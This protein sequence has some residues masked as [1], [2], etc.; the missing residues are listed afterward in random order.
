MP[1]STHLQVRYSVNLRRKGDA[2]VRS[3][4]GLVTYLLYKWLEWCQWLFQRMT[5]FAL[6]SFIREFLG[7]G[8]L[9][10]NANVLDAAK[11]IKTR[12]CGGTLK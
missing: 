6:G 1:E 11:Q 12:I 10:L 2:W 4:A 3:S 9:I 8:T 5:Y 7:V